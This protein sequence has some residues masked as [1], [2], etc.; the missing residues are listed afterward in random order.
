MH[1][2]DFTHRSYTC[3]ITK[4]VFN[5]KNQLQVKPDV[6]F[7]LIVLT[8]LNRHIFLHVHTLHTMC[9]QE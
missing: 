3:Y 6:K 5:P 1:I 4:F 8:T 2:L 9:V 7:N